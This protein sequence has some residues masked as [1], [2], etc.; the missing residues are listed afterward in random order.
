MFR[1]FQPLSLIVRHR[2]RAIE[3]V[4]AIGKFFKDETTD[5][6]TV[7]EEERH[8]AAANLEDRSGAW[9]PVGAMAE[10][11]VEK[12]GVMDAKLADRRI[13]R[14]H[15]GGEVGR[16]LHLLARGENIELVGVKDE[17]SIAP[18]D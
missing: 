5:R 12:A 14:R 4:G 11:G 15:L 10:A 2:R 6:L 18:R 8:I 16:D 17:P 7:F 1:Q 13:N 9:P 3:R